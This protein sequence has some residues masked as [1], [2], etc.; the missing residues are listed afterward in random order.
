MNTAQHFFRFLRLE[1]RSTTGA[2]ATQAWCGSHPGGARA[3]ATCRRGAGSPRRPRCVPGAVPRRRGSGSGRPRGS[4]HKRN[5]AQPQSVDRSPRANLIGLHRAPPRVSKRDCSRET[6]AL[7]AM[8]PFLSVLNRGMES[9]P[10][11][12]TK[13][14]A[15]TKKTRVSDKWQEQLLS[16]N[17]CKSEWLCLLC[18]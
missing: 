4:P 13:G 18:L 14:L 11:T 5:S 1:P 10:V 2:A 6:E 17:T 15:W 3:A 12:T 9:A 8:S 16:R 7:Q